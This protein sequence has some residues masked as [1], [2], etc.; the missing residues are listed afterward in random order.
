[1]C[2]HELQPWD[3]RH[4]LEAHDVPF[5]DGTSEHL[6]S[7]YRALIRS[8]ILCNIRWGMSS[9]QD[10]HTVVLTACLDIS[11]DRWGTQLPYFASARPLEPG[12]NTIVVD[13]Y[14]T[15]TRSHEHLNHVLSNGIFH[16][17]DPHTVYSKK[18]LLEQLAIHDMVFAVTTLMKNALSMSRADSEIPKHEQDA[19]PDLAA[20]VQ[21]QIQE[22]N[23]NNPISVTPAADQPA[24]YRPVR[25]SCGS[26]PALDGTRL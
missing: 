22:R 1:M 3:P 16:R 11:A 6:M 25:Y 8:G 12:S 9:D 19:N 5:V 26:V 15:A 13:L 23:L 20:Y 17:A 10:N 18:H 4:V 7:N 2:Y 21:Q 24:T 14:S